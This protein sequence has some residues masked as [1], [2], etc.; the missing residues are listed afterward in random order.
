MMANHD[1]RAG[2]RTDR[3]SRV[4]VREPILGYYLIVTD[5]KETEKNYFEGLKKA[6]PAQIKDRIVIKVVKA[7]TT[8]NLVEK[9]KELC[10]MEAQHRIPWIVVDRDLVKDFD[11]LVQ[12]ALDNEF[13]VGWSNPCFEIWLFAYLG[14]MPNLRDSVSCC[15]EFA[16]RFEKK[17]S[18][19]YRKNDTDLYARLSALGNFENAYQIAERII[20]RAESERKKPSESCPACTVH[21]LVKEIKDKT[22]AP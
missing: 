3:N 9:T 6:I 7:K 18:H 15:K 5:T 20:S 12:D 21:R 19:P 4:G 17:T 16:L 13:H 14:E 2:K 1:H 11:G 8:Y 10:S 22:D